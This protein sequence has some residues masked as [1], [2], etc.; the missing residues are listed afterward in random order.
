VRPMVVYIFG[1]S[2][3]YV[4]WA[5]ASEEKPRR[6]DASLFP[7][8]APLLEASQQYAACSGCR[9]IMNDFDGLVD[10]D[11]SSPFRTVGHARGGD[12]GPLLDAKLQAM[13]VVEQFAASLRAEVLDVR[14]LE[15]LE[16]AVAIVAAE[17]TLNAMAATFK[18]LDM[19]PPPP[20]SLSDRG[21]YRDLSAPIPL[22][23]QRA[24]DHRM[25]RFGSGGP[26][27]STR[28]A[29]TASFLTD[30]A[31][32]VSVRLPAVP[33]EEQA[34][35]DKFVSV[36]SEYRPTPRKEDSDDFL[37]GLL[38]LRREGK[39]WWVENRDTVRWAVLGVAA[40]AATAV[41]D[42]AK[43]PPAEARCV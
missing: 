17:S 34:F 9:F 41:T 21:D 24:H 2:V 43:R 28:E 5:M 31:H 38:G 26:Q 22:I 23:A 37:G 13:P 29:Q 18:A 7:N 19:W 8:F 30:F 12:S 33:A 3:T 20:L 14:L 27:Q 6:L 42:S 16:K 35:L 32:E 25:R 39:P 11:S 15:E 40:A 10:D 1:A 4:L 36:A